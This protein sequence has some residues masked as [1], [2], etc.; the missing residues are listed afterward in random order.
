MAAIAS[1]GSQSAPAWDLSTISTDVKKIVDTKVRRAGS[2]EF[3]PV[4]A[5]AFYMS[6]PD[7]TALFTLIAAPHKNNVQAEYPIIFIRSAYENAQHTDPAYFSRKYASWLT[8]GYAVV[9]QHCRGTGASEG[10]FIPYTA[11]RAD[12]LATL[13]QLRKLPFYNAEIFLIG[14]SYLSTTHYAYLDQAPDD[15]K[16]AVLQVQA[17]DRYHF[18][19]RNNILKLSS[20]TWRFNQYR[21]KTISK[22]NFSINSFKALP[23]ADLTKTVFG[24]SMIDIDDMLRSPDVNDAYWQTA[25]GGVEV[26]KALTNYKFPILFIGGLYD[27]Y[28]EENFKMWR[29]LAPEQRKISAM[30]MT[31]YD[32]A[33]TTAYYA[34]SHQINFEKGSLDK[35]WP[36]FSYHFFEYCRNNDKK[37]DFIKSGNI[38]YY[39]L[40]E[41]RWYTEPDLAD[42][43]QKLQLYLGNHTLQDKPSCGSISYKYDPLN[44]ATFP[45]GCNF[46]LGN[47]LAK[48]HRPNWRHDVKSFISEPFD[49]ALKIR[50]RI[51]A[52]VNIKSDCD[53]SA[54]YLRLSIIKN[55]IPYCLREDIS[56]ISKQHPDY[57]PGTVVPMVFNFTEHAFLLEKGDRLR[58]DISSSCWPTFLPHTNFKGNQFYHTSARI[59]NN[60]I[61]FDNSSMTLNI[62]P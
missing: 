29:S 59:A 13:K 20:T 28:A 33:H 12:G 48:Q 30:I 56:P 32:H 9:L 44:P 45:G 3:V 46:R 60:T 43:T 58:L 25:A 34:K 62:L 61:V 57:R 53:D 15:I 19:Y 18:S 39:S 26:K 27:V 4:K 37:P 36:D 42:G 11:E 38:T 21:K 2:K 50:G 22:R 49:K 23:L 1:L 16:G 35:E 24:K 52:A 40:W 47:G 55:N 10:D 14:K 7:K 8:R 17:I 41:K 31:P 54:F 6:M 51:R 5:A